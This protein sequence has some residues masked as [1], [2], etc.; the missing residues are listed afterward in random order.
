LK[1]KSRFCTLVYPD[2][3]P[4]NHWESIGMKSTYNSA[5]GVYKERTWGNID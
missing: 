1:K 5:I 2:K 4:S 3:L